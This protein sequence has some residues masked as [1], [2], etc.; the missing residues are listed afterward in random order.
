M[1]IGV[2]NDWNEAL[3]FM[4]KLDSEKKSKIDRT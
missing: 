1:K 4:K 3:E 2:A